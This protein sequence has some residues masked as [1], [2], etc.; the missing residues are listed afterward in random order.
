[1]NS[2]LEHLGDRLSLIFSHKDRFEYEASMY[3]LIVVD[4][5]RSM[6]L[7]NSAKIV[8]EMLNFIRGILR[9]SL[10]RDA[11]KEYEMPMIAAVL[12]E[13]HKAEGIEA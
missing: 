5:S 1:M 11:D 8:N 4:L 3:R 12:S 6:D 2:S 7:M 13:Q 9:V 10:L